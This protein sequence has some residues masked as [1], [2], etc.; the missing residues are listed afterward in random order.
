[1]QEH[2]DCYHYKPRIIIVVSCELYVAYYRF[3]IIKKRPARERE[4]RSSDDHHAAE[5]VRDCSLFG[6][7]HQHYLLN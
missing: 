6:A 5:D 2:P 4:R 7:G 1:M 3:P